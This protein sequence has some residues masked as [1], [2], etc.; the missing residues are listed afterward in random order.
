MSNQQLSVVGCKQRKPEYL[1]GLKYLKCGNLP[2][3][4]FLF[5]FHWKLLTNMLKRSSEPLS[6]VDFKQKYMKHG[7][8]ESEI[9]LTINEIIII[10]RYM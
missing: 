1:V 2:Y 8:Q 4:F 5:G 6:E 9:I 10:Q 7:F 3:P